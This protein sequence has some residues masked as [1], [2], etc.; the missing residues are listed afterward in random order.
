MPHLPLAR[1]GPTGDPSRQG[2][3]NT[4]EFNSLHGKPPFEPVDAQPTVRFVDE[5]GSI[6]PIKPALQ[7]AVGPMEISLPESWL[8]RLRKFP[9]NREKNRKF[10]HSAKSLGYH[11][12]RQPCSTLGFRSRAARAPLAPLL[13]EALNMN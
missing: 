2:I 11:D 13:D 3:E 1:R 12:I 8:E 7:S 4:F 5:F 10:H 6:G 9:P